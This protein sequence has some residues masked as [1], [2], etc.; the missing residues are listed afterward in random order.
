MS[1][2][3][4]TVLQVNFKSPGGTLINVYASDPD[5]FDQVLEFLVSRT[6]A[7]ASAES[8]L[9]GASNVAQALP[10]SPQQPVQPEQP[11]VQQWGTPATPPQTGGWGAPT[12]PPQASG[13]VPTCVHGERKAVKG[14]GKTG[15]WR[16]YMCPTAKGTPGQ[17]EPIWIDKKDTFAWNGFPG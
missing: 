1:A 3:S 15:E 17:C 2:S 5:R 12:A 6:A 9:N 4:D 16:A 13:P 11:P 10:L 14:N 8:L 7:I